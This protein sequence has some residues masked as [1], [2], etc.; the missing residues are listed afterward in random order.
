MKKSLAILLTVVLVLAA[1]PSGMS[2]SYAEVSFQDVPKDAWYYEH[3]QYVANHPRELMVGY[4][5][6]FGPLDNLITLLPEGITQ[7]VRNDPVVLNKKYSH[8]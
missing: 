7:T 1:M 2:R 4:A 3:V 8:T 5:G 6:N